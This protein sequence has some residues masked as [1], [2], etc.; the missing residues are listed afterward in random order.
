MAKHHS[1]ETQLVELE[2]LLDITDELA[3]VNRGFATYHELVASHLYKSSQQDVPHEECL[4]FLNGL[5]II[6]Y[7]L[8]ARA[9]RVESAIDDNRRTVKAI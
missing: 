3:K 5:H 4:R 2:S 1:T 7:S 9:E 6:F 8:L